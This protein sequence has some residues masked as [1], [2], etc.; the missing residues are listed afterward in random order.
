MININMADMI[1]SCLSRKPTTKELDTFIDRAMNKHDFNYYMLFED[2]KNKVEH[3]KILSLPEA[4]IYPMVME[5]I[6]QR[7]QEDRH[8]EGQNQ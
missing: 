3:S 1:G 2:L 5:R 8:K 6:A 7:H 4:E